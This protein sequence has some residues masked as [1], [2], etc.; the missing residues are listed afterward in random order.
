M[1]YLDNIR[2]IERRIRIAMDR[3][4]TEPSE[5][6]PFGLP[7]SKH[8]HYRLMYD[9]M[10]LAFQ[11]DLTRSVTY[12]VGRISPARA[13]PNPVSPADGTAL[14]TMATNPTMWPIT[15]RSIDITC[16]TSPTSPTS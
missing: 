14:R 11:G 13:S 12:M 4:V 9:L 10:A 16:R 15:P 7:A 5:E 1:T 6:I 3:P 2:E 8:V